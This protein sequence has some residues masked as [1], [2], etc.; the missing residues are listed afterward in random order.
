[1][2]MS[3]ISGC[4]IENRAPE[5]APAGE[6]A[7]IQNAVAG[8]YQELASSD[9]ALATPAAFGAATVLIAVAGADP[10]LVTRGTFAG[11][12]E[13][14]TASGGIRLV[15]NEIRIDGELASVRQVVVSRE[16]GDTAEFEATDY[17]TLGRRDGLW[18]VA[19]AL[20]GSWH[21]R[22]SS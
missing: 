18:Q 9:T 12:P 15:R 14:R 20:F 13:R 22:S 2:I 7:A 19:H 17:L 4:S 21:P 1:M 3:L 6:E 16:Q 11:L 5:G 8:F 10:A